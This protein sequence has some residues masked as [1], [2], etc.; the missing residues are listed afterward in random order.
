MW[1]NLFTKPTK[2]TRSLDEVMFEI[3]QEGGWLSKADEALSKARKKY[4]VLA[5]TLDS[6]QSPDKHAEGPRVNDHIRLMLASLYAIVD[7][8]LKLLEIEEFARMKGYEGEIEEIENTI[9]ERAAWYEVF[10]LMHDLAK[11]PT[12]RFIPAPE[13]LGQELGFG[14]LKAGWDEIGGE[15]RLVWQ[16]TY[17]D[18][19]AGF[20][21]TRVGEK[22]QMIQ[23][24]FFKKYGISVSNWGHA[25]AIYKPH[26]EELIRACAKE[27]RL[28]DFDTDLLVDI[29]A[30]HLE[31]LV[32]FRKGAEP[33]D[34]DYL[35]AHANRQGY[36]ADDYLDLLQGCVL[37]D[38][39][40]GRQAVGP[41]GY[42]HDPVTLENMLRA[43]HDWAPW[44][45]EAGVKQKEQEA[46]KIKK[47]VM[48]EFGLDG[49]SI[50]SLTGMTPGP[51]LGKLLKDIKRAID[52]LG[53]LPKIDRKH[54]TEIMRRIG[55]ARIKLTNL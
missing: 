38:M 54:E 22:R 15:E 39:V 33:K 30:M 3:I 6:P 37:L 53:Y 47:Q 51:E 8:R 26:L 2:P 41:Y 17:D 21:A 7:G 42:W 20:A 36:D 9:K 28:S 1:S 55:E 14:T 45:K 10:A 52:E 25:K 31:P 11:G 35:L 16:K 43:E 18:L 19:Y 12:V 44:K 40:L 50:M 49:S 13:S 23:V 4:P 34:Y 32:R 46:D 24:E 48:K 5:D 27:Y 29:I